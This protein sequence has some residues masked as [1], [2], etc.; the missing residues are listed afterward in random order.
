MA[1]LI[2]NEEVFK[3]QEK[4]DESHSPSVS[5]NNGEVSMQK[6]VFWGGLIKTTFLLRKYKEEKTKPET[7]L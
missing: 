6:W 2:D 7:M 4:W 3:L 5:G 1:N